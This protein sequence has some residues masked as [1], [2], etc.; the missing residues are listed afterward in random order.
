MDEATRAPLKRTMQW[1]SWVDRLISRF[2]GWARV[3]TCGLYPRGPHKNRPSLRH[4]NWPAARDSLNGTP[5]Q[6][7]HRFPGL[8]GTTPP[9]SRSRRWTADRRGVGEI[10]FPGC[11][12]L[13]THT[14][15]AL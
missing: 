9:S 13:G 14:L 12:E 15:Q 4:V 6:R 10:A 3:V 8:R 2:C 5:V 11:S 1:F 7:A